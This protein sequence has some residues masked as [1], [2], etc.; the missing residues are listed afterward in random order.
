MKLLGSK[1]LKSRGGIKRWGRWARS[2]NNARALPGGAVPFTPSLGYVLSTVLSL[3]IFQKAKAHGQRAMLM[4][5][6]H[7]GPSRT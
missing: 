4:G 5:T 1:V 6:A 2:R 7:W 3:Q